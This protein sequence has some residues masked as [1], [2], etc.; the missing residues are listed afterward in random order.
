MAG[1]PALLIPAQG[2][3]H[4]T[5]SQA[6]PWLGVQRPLS[7]LTI[8]VQLDHYR[9]LEAFFIFHNYLVFAA[10]FLPKP[11]DTQSAVLK[12]FCLVLKI[13]IIVMN[14]LA[15]LLLQDLL[16]MV[17]KPFDLLISL[18]DGNPWF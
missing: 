4:C 1:D 14:R 11:H 13:L 3:F 2:G 17:V 6:S 12:Q 16:G 5:G 9:D 7:I 15:L 10:V 8:D 18:Q